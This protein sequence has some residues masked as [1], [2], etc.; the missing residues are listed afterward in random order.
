M[1]VEPIT[2]NPPSEL[3]Q[4]L[5]REA[6]D[7]AAGLGGK[8]GFSDAMDK[9]RAELNAK[10]AIESDEALVSFFESFTDNEEG[11][12]GYSAS[13]D[14]QCFE[15][16]KRA[17]VT[18]MPA[19]I[20]V[21]PGN[22][23]MSLQTG[24]IH[25][26]GNRAVAV[27]NEEQA[28][29]FRT[30]AM[31]DYGPGKVHGTPPCYR[32][33][34]ERIQVGTILISESLLSDDFVLKGTIWHECGHKYLGDKNESGAVFVHEITLMIQGFDAV[35]ARKWIMEVGRTPAY[36]RT[37]GLRTEPGRKELLL[38]LQ[39]ICTPKEF[40]L[41]FN[42]QFLEII[43][44]E[45]SKPDAVIEEEKP[46]VLEQ[47]LVQRLDVR[48]GTT[49]KGKLAD[50]KLT[51]AGYDLTG[52]RGSVRPGVALLGENVTFAGMKWRLLD[53]TSGDI[54]VFELECIDLD[55]GLGVT[56]R[57]TV[58]VRTAGNRTT[59]GLLKE[60]PWPYADLPTAERDQ[61]IVVQVVT[62]TMETFTNADVQTVRRL[63]VEQVLTTRENQ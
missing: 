37:Y 33:L 30:V 22:A 12:G 34:L 29:T 3:I 11:Y 59:F 4:R 17:G 45:L 20:M 23:A 55:D 26:E 14:E 52:A 38:L 53:K 54:V 42:K 61:E 6:R 18:P 44:E 46:K 24:S 31:T 15:I 50:L 10:K 19:D 13:K 5:V 47:P 16:M 8:R 43:G 25:G 57:G 62:Q 48:V 40:Y 9:E 32:R 60:G 1:N 58:W 21:M 28:R 27:M 49:I 63:A 35:R 39:K 51:L 2:E 36:H 7:S 41:E 56:Q